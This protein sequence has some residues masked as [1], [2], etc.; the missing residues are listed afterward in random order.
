M[1]YQVIITSFTVIIINGISG[2]H[3]WVKINTRVHMFNISNMTG[4]SFKQKMFFKV[5]VWQPVPSY[6]FN[7]CWL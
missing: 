2:Y 7:L 1:V 4:I 5:G 6:C 3:Y